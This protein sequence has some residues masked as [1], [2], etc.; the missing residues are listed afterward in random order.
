MSHELRTPLNSLLILSK[1]LLENERGNLS[2][3]QLQFARTIYAAGTDLL[4]LISDI[5][6]LSKIEAGKME[7]L[8]DLVG[9]ADV[10]AYVTR[11]FDPIAADK[12]LRFEID[13]DPKL[14]ATILTDEQRLE[15]ILRNL[16]SNAFKFTDSGGVTLSLR[17]LPDERV[18][19]AVSDTGVGIPPDKLQV[20]FEAFQ[21]ADGTTS[22]KYGGTGLGLSISRELARALGGKIRV[23]ST[24][25]DGATFT[26]ILPTTY[27]RPLGPSF[28]GPAEE[29][30]GHASPAPLPA[31]ASASAETRGSAQ[32]PTADAAVALHLQPERPAAGPSPAAWH[33]TDELPGQEELG[34][35]KALLVDDDA[36]N[37]FALASLLEDRG[38]EVLFG[39]T[40]QEALAALERDPD[41]DIVLMDIM[42]PDIDGNE[43]IAAIRRMPARRELPVIAVTAKAM[44]GD[45]ER[46]L[47]A[48]ASDYITK[49]VEAE[50]LLSLIAT[51][52]QS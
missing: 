19:F 12:S 44:E 47:S 51:W 3:K 45:R 1:L 4:Q 8:P 9:L 32:Q 37:L 27:S 35:K 14:P 29:D 26:L 50:R 41:I 6:D 49:P 7:I 21:Q 5:L 33:A 23:S 2:E 28:D 46:S 39:E 34:G 48:G 13:A 18:S 20:I 38:M 16:L 15:Q 22:R 25:G 42:M 52:L 40:G 36:R 31:P 10:Q 24:V 11:T 43:T 17:W 30:L